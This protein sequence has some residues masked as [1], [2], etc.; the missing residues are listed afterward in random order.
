MKCLDMDVKSSQSCWR[1]EV[2]IGYMACI[3]KVVGGRAMRFYNKDGDPC[4]NHTFRLFCLLNDLIVNHS[5][6][7]TI[8]LFLQS[9]FN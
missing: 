5:V 3:Y 2:T 7:H 9:K 4:H 1:Q 8:N 6:S